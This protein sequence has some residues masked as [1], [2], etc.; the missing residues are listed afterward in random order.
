MCTRNPL[1]YGLEDVNNWLSSGVSPRATIAL[2]KCS[3]AVAWLNGRDYVT[4]EDV[5]EIAVPVLNHRIALTY[6]AA[7]DKMTAEKIIEKILNEI[8]MG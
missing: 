3:R 7:S 4:P 8:P 6:D 2:D 5:R 1:S